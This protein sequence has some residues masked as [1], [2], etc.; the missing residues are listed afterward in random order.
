MQ[1]GDIDHAAAIGELIIADAWDLQS[2][3]VQGDI[4]ALPASIGSARSRTAGAF[5]EQAREFLAARR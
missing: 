5:T 1:A 3:H 4:A 2:R